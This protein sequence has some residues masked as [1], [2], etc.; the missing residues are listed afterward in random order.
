MDRKEF[1]KTC[2]IAC[3]GGTAAISTLLQSCASSYHYTHGEIDQSNLKVLKSEFTQNSK[4]QAVA[5]KYILVKHDKLNYPIY[6]YKIS[7]EQ[8]SALWMEC[9]HQG[10]ELS[11]QGEY[12]TCPAHGSEFDKLGNVTQGPA[13]KNLRQ[14]KTST[15]TQY[16]YIQLS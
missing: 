6:L 10:A 16:I 1:L 8:Y 14:F 4:G 7:E 5:R 3:L 9:T 15:D 12:L 11:S 13:Q 2:G